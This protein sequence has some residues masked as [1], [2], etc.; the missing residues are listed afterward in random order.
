MHPA[1]LNFRHLMYFWMVAKEGSITRAAER[2]GLSVQTISTQL[3]QLERQLG[4]SLLAPQGRSLT[5]TD[6]GRT[7]L[8]YAEQIFHLGAELRR[9][10]AETRAARPHFTVGVTDA[11]PKLLAFRLLAAVM[12]APLSV[13]LECREGNFDNLL[14]ELALNRL[15]LVIAD[16]S[17]PQLANLKLHSHLLATE[18]IDLYGTDDFH[19]VYAAGFPGSINGAPILLPI[20]GDPLRPAIDA[21]FEARDLRPE[22]VG[23]FSDSALLKT[24]GR[25][26]VGLFPA[27]AGM[28]EEIAA[29][30]RA[31]PIGKLQGVSETW[32]AISTQRRIQHPA[33]SAIVAAGQSNLPT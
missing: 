33:I 28:S 29:Q 30:Y 5:L 32:Y 24:F 9:G 15:D 14:G 8:G 4:Y 17:A 10:L 1:D 12:R 22:V 6:A 2:L 3:G 26:G 19:R 7:A 20:R 21:W 27:P 23:E 11:V 18:G 25:A 31:R 13:R 16:R